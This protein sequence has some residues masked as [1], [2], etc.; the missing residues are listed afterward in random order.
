[1]LT[2]HRASFAGAAS[3]EGTLLDF[4][5]YPGLIVGGAKG[6]VSGELY[7]VADPRSLFAGARPDR[8]VSRFRRT[9]LALSPRDRARGASGRRRDAGVDLC[10]QRRTGGVRAIESGD[11]CRRSRP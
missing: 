8:D 10:L 3:V 6:R 9:G 4:G 1:M 7:S 2:R 11:W 5:E